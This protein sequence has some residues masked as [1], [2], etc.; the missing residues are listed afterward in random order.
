M[1]FLNFGA[2]QAS[3]PICI[4][5]KEGSYVKRSLETYYV[6]PLTSSGIDPDDIMA[7]PL[8][9]GSNNKVTVKQT[10]EHLDQ[11]APMLQRLGVK[12]LFC[13]DTTYFKQL[14]K[15]KKSENCLDKSVDCTY[16]GF[17]GIKAVYT[18]NFSSLAYNPAQQEK[19]DMSVASLVAA[20]KG[21]SVVRSIPF[22]EKRI[23]YDYDSIKAEL[24]S[25][26]QYDEL[27][28]D[29]EAFSLKL[30]KAGI[31]TITFAESTTSGTAFPVD[32]HAIEPQDGFYGMR[33]D[34][35][36]V[37]ALLKKFFEEY[38]GNLTWHGSAYDLKQIVW[39]LWM[40]HPL[41]RENMLKG[42][43]VMT[44]NM[45]DT[46]FVAFLCLNSTTR[47][48]LGLKA[49]GFPYAG[50]YG[51]E[52]IKDVRRIPLDQL[53]NYNLSDGCVTMWVKDQYW[54]RMF[55][56]KQDQV[57]LDFLD[58]QKVLLATELHGMPMSDERLQEVDRILCSKRDKLQSEIMNSQYVLDAEVILINKAVEAANKKLKVK[59]KSADDFDDL[60]FNPGSDQQLRVLLHSVLKL[61]VLKVTPTKEPKTD[62]DTLKML[63]HKAKKKS[64]KELIQNIIDYSEVCTVIN[65][66][67]KAF[68]EGM[69]KADGRRY[70][71]GNFNIA[72]V[73]SGRLSSS[74]PNL[75]NIPAGSTYGKLIKSIFQAPDGFLWVYSDF[76]S[77]EDYI[78]ALQSKDT[79]KLKVYLG[80]EIYELKVSGK[81]HIC[82]DDSII[83]WRGDAYTFA[84][85]GKLHAPNPDAEFPFAS[86]YDELFAESIDIKDEKFSI[87]KIGNSSGYDGHCLRAFSYFRDR[88]PNY[89]DNVK[90]INSI[91]KLDEAIR[92][93]SKVPTFLLTYG[94]SWRGIMDKLGFTE[95]LSKQISDNYHKLYVESDQYKE[96]RLDE[97]AELGYM[98]LAF[99]LRIRCPLLK[100]T[101]RKSGFSARGTSEDERTLG[102]AIGQSYGMLNNRAMIAFMRKVWESP[103]RLRIFPIAPIHDASYYSIAN[104]IDV[105][106]FVNTHLIKEM[107]WQEDPLIAHPRVKIGAELDIAYPNWAHACTI[108]NGA[109]KEKIFETT[110][111]HMVNLEKLKKEG[112]LYV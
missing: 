43:D 10:K 63:I 73:K 41:D 32:Y 29:I 79:N 78:S 9:Y 83:R 48:N 25:L 11:L 94:G 42:V 52:E 84:D 93:E 82:R 31:A 97:A 101:I 30:G 65:T 8:F 64:V 4:L 12:Y 112:K 60:V 47:P 33:K 46:H 20:T 109:S 77:L 85:F 45:D 50:D 19:I 23:H 21:A 88:L 24:E 27:A 108:P 54:D 57:Y 69:L 74:D 62:A 100:N 102:N 34:N 44:R 22:T 35:P 75:Q 95:Q 51:E 53:L 56:E 72:K 91:K 111:A 98:V 2:R 90:S 105:I 39:E 89:V 3:Y 1:N 17:E 110:E 67:I 59:K 86:Q 55:A 92:G 87:K 7:A 37:R 49:L 106:N 15:E 80:H 76:N 5:I 66:F 28:C 36:K 99:G 38:Q 16:P 14:T 18:L 107:Q 40:D 58:M 71:H 81:T 70:L 103:Y 96:R 6:A 26:H 61:P 13:A 68:K 104:D